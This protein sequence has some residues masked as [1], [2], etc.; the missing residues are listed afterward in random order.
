M[1]KVRINLVNVLAFLL[2]ILVVS[3]IVLFYFLRM[4]SV[5]NNDVM[6]MIFVFILT[7][8]F[9]ASSLFI[10]NKEKKNG[11]FFSTDGLLLGNASKHI[12]IPWDNLIVKKSQ[13]ILGIVNYDLLDGSNN[14]RIITF[15]WGWFEAEDMIKLT[16]KYVPK[17]H[18]LY[19][20]VSEKYYLNL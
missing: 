17:H 18:E 12:K 5:E 3:C 15:H 13:N 6:K 16:K 10:G 9:V 20:I 4:I 19:R 1:E 2:P 8:G 14:K 11:L 7:F